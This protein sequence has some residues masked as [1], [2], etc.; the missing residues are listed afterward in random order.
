IIICEWAATHYTTRVNPPQVCTT[1]CMQQIDS[2]YNNV[3]S[4]FPKLK[5]INWFSMNTLSTNKCNFSLTENSQV[6]NK[7]KSVVQNAYYKTSYFRNVPLVKFVN[8]SEDTVL[9]SNGFAQVNV[10]CDTPIDSVVLFVDNQRHSLSASSSYLLEIRLN[11]IQDGVHLLKAIAYSQ[12]G[13][14]NFE[15]VRV[16]VD[17]G[18]VYSI[19]VVDDSS[20]SF[21][22][23]GN[24]YIS[25]SQP[26]RFGP[27]Y[28]VSTS[29]NGSNK[30]YWKTKLR[31]N[32]YYNV[33]AYWSAH[34]NRGRNVPYII[35]HSISKDTIRVNQQL[36]G[37]QWN[38]LGSFYF[39]SNDSA[40]V[41]ITNDADGYVIADA[42][43]FEWK[44]TSSI[45][46]ENVNAP[47]DFILFQNYPNPFNSATMIKFQIHKSAFTTLKVFDILGREVTTLYKGN[48]N[49]G[50][51]NSELQIPNSSLSS[52]TYFYA[53]NVDGVI[54]VKKM[55]YLK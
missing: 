2:L 21:S 48:L 23:I 22:F 35:H 7:Y 1:Y 32:G 26:D 43:K 50:F 5:A 10:I 16:I 12:S 39:Q 28:H 34:P 29:G 54:Q 24:W 36:N 40:V 55:V 9:R 18:N 14:Y 46:E 41:E 42:V 6:L 11:E 52:G 17:K 30:A 27:Y 31:S 44:F 47:N 33:Y 19:A 37:G 51:Y 8:I 3:N 4:Q 49:P 13:F 15:T 25:T 20:K 53:L 38:L 45:A